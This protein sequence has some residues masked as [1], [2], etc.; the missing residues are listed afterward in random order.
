MK[1]SKKIISSSIIIYALCTVFS[2]GESEADIIPNHNILAEKEAAVK[3]I[4]K[5]TNDSVHSGSN[6][7]LDENGNEITDPPQK[8][9]DQWRQQSANIL[10][11]DQEDN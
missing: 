9:K 5:S 10:G 2:C 6:L 7:K 3:L 8:D 4:N 1:T 11:H